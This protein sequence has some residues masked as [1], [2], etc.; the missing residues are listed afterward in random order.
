MPAV[1]T[2][3]VTNVCVYVRVC[4]HD[5]SQS[6]NQCLAAVATSANIG[7]FEDNNGIGMSASPAGVAVLPA[8]C[9]ELVPPN[10]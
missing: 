9:F 5:M 4:Y 8:G 2:C 10:S 3:V 7:Y 6:M 1:L